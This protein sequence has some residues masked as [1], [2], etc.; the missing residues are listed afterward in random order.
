[1]M[2][3]LNRFSDCLK[4]R[5]C[6]IQKYNCKVDEKAEKILKSY[7][8]CLQYHITKREDWVETIFNLLYGE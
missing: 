3:L 2:S 4:T 1:M 5:K 8:E 7:A 6:R